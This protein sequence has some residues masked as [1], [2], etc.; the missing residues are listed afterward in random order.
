MEEAEVDRHHVSA[1]SAARLRGLGK[2]GI[3][4]EHKDL[5][6]CAW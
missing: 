3:K 6:L 4:E 5:S 1:A 2:P